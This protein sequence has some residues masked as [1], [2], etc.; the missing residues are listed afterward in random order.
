MLLAK[1]KSIE[2]CLL[3][4]R[5]G[6]EEKVCLVGCSFYIRATASIFLAGKKGRTT[7]SLDDFQKSLSGPESPSQLAA[8]DAGNNIVCASKPRPVKAA[9][10]QGDVRGS[11][12]IAL[13]L[14]KDA[15]SVPSAW[16]L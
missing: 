8:A 7:Q 11:S 5:G 6:C 16:L 1:S 2:G 15:H 13:Q 14:W 3:V 4:R 10:W 9:W 12:V